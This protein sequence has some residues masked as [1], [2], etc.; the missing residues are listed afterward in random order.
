MNSKVYEKQ[1]QEKVKTHKTLFQDKTSRR[2]ITTIC[3]KL[4]FSVFPYAKKKLIIGN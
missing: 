4:Q 1:H 3:Q 2:K